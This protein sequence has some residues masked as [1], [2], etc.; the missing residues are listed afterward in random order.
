M[1]VRNVLTENYTV[2]QSHLPLVDDSQ[3]LCLR[4]PIIK[5][6]KVLKKNTYIR[7]DH[8]CHNTRYNVYK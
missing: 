5:T 6:Y 7:L 2:K 1:N 3:H 4:N 8:K